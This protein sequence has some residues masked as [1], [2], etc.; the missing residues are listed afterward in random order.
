MIMI[1]K[2]LWIK[3]I[4]TS[5][6]KIASREYQERAWLRNEIYAPC[7]FEEMMC[8]LF[9]DCF[10]REFVNEKAD[11]FG[12]S[13]E[14]K[15]ALSELVIALDKYDDNPE[16]Y[17]SNYPLEVDESKVLLDPKWHEI[18]KIAQRL[19][20]SFGKIKYDLED[21]EWWL[22]FILHSISTYS[23]TEK[24]RRMWINKSE[25]F[26][27][28]PFDMY[29]GLFTDLEFDD[30][31]DKYAKN[32]ALTEDQIADLDRF[33]FQ[34]KTTPF[35]TTNPENILD[36]PDWGKIVHYAREVLDAFDYKRY[37]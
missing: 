34:L 8:G 28:T 12:L 23:D 1:K 13:T 21:K 27:S 19:L 14:Q 30:F 9:D 29:E 25:V 2:N 5:V 24:Q 31:I 15:T 35:K 10:I 32:F 16:I 18:R 4:L 22:Q 26:W 33:R 6:Q 3:N 7:S 20:S 17:F 37:S 11:E 36:S